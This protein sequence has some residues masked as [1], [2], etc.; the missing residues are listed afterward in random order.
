MK[1]IQPKLPPRPTTKHQHEFQEICEELEPIYGKAV[2]T[3]PHQPGVTEFKLRRAHA[4]AR[5]RGITKLPY[6]I[7]IIKKLP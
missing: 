6:L 7:G 3:L 4:I 2:W 5:S 1:K